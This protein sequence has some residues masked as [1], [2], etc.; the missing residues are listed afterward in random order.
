[1]DSHDL[2]LNIFE[3]I[4]TKQY[5]INKNMH[6]N[7]LNHIIKCK[8]IILKFFKYIK[9]LKK[10]YKYQYLILNKRCFTKNTL[11]KFVV[12]NYIFESVCGLPE[13]IVGSHNIQTH[14]LDILPEIYYRRCFHLYLFLKQKMIT[15]DMIID[16]WYS[17]Y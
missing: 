1:M 3:Y 7:Y 14:L 8:R 10:I 9:N 15:S 17:F 13:I 12:L 5:K 16:C 6:K 2:I 4:P 11:I